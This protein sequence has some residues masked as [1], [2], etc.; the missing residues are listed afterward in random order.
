MEK[1]ET[2]EEIFSEQTREIKKLY[3]LVMNLQVATEFE[4]EKAITRARMTG[5]ITYNQ[6]AKTA[7]ALSKHFLILRK[8]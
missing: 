7:K 3:D 4:V 6:T 8:K 1:K 5:K 2:I